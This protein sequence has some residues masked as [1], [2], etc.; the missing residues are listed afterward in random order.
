[1]THD[2]R[3]ITFTGS[4]VERLSPLRQQ[5]DELAAAFAATDT[6]FVPIWQSRCLLQDG[7]VVVC[8]R[9]DLEPVAGGHEA[10][11]FLGRRRTA[12]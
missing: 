8:R 11:V 7:G 9:E 4:G 2:S 12:T 1:M 5:A 10:A 6:R 3:R